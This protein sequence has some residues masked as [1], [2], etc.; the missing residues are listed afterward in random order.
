MFSFYVFVIKGVL[1]HSERLH[2]WRSE[3]KREDFQG[4]LSCITFDGS[5]TGKVSRSTVITLHIH[6]RFHGNM[7]F[8]RDISVWTKV[9]DQSTDI[10]I[11]KT[12]LLAQLKIW[13]DPTGQKIP[14]RCSGSVLVSLPAL[15]CFCVLSWQ[16]CRRVCLD[17]LC[18]CCPTCRS[19]RCS[20]SCCH[21]N[22][23]R[24]GAEERGKTEVGPYFFVFLI[25]TLLVLVA[26][27]EEEMQ[28]ELMMMTVLHLQSSYFYAKTFFK[29][30]MAYNFITV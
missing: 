8:I 5:T 25:R 11:Y 20:P 21:P 28:K 22:Y 18:W 19:G 12:V 16:R 14:S 23:S 3:D 9:M 6:I 17:H 24:E 15:P 29:I 4:T 13:N 27:V 1:Q 30:S 26:D 7:S 2:H 10:V